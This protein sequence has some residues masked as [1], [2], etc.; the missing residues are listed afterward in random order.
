MK[1]FIVKTNMILLIFMISTSSFSQDSTQVKKKIFSSFSLV[2]KVNFIQFS[3]L[4][5]KLSEYNY[6]EIKNYIQGLGFEI[7]FG[8]RTNKAFVTF[9]PTVYYQ[10]QENSS[11][12]VNHLSFEGEIKLDYNIL[13]TKTYWI[14]PYLGLSYLMNKY[15][16][17]QNQETL[18]SIVFPGTP[19]Y[20]SLKSNI[21]YNIDLGI[22]ADWQCFTFSSIG[23]RT[24]YR[25]ALNTGNF[26]YKGQ[27]TS[28]LP[29]ISYNSIYLGGVLSF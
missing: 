26:I 29:N 27:T 9:A 21:I 4:N 7:I 28:A 15:E 19:D 1:N 24:G 25:I 20:S 22:G 16:L 17:H 23:F 13:N 18:A 2:N 6:P 8:E 5:T 3:D 10:N 14:H 12:S 11:S